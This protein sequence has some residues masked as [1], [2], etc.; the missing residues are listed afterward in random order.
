MWFRYVPLNPPPRPDR[1]HSPDIKIAYRLWVS[2]GRPMSHS[3]RELDDMK[4]FP[5]TE[6][7]AGLGYFENKRKSSRHSS[8]M[9][10]P[11]SNSKLVVSLNTNG[12]WRFFP[13]GSTG[14]GGTVIDAL[15][16]IMGFSI[17]QCRQY[18]RPL[19]SGSIPSAR[20]PDPSTYSL[21]LVPVETDIAE[22]RRMYSQSV[23]PIKNGIHPYL[24]QHRRISATLLADPAFRGAVLTDR[25]RNAVFPHRDRDGQIVGAE[26]R[27]V[28]F[29]G[30]IKGGRKTLWY[31]HNVRRE[32]KRKSLLIAESGID[33]CSYA[34]LF[35]C[36]DTCYL[37]TGGTFSPTQADL[38]SAAIKK[39]PSTAGGMV[40]V[41]ADHDKAGDEIAAQ[42]Q[43]IFESCDRNDLHFK[44]HQPDTSGWDWNDQ[45]VHTVDPSPTPNLDL[46]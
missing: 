34:A 40:T 4:R 14:R 31:S 8:F 13:I 45:L 36:P 24:N 17:G 39:L 9:V 37:S 23:K 20:R 30:Q 21:Q 6:V 18:M 42:I 38:I 44:I 43:A 11:K 12:H 1:F 28:A 3:D 7:L 26:L 46:G 15:A 41:A 33:A 16:L 22:V 2:Y 25:R 10:N 19:L 29:Q 5:L 32:E 27:N 35:Y